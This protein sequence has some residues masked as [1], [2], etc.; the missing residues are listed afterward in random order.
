MSQGGVCKR[1]TLRMHQKEGPM[2]PRMPLALCET[3]HQPKKHVFHSQERVKNLKLNPQSND[4]ACTW[5]WWKGWEVKAS[6]A[7]LF[8]SLHLLSRLHQ[9]P[10]WTR[11]M[12][13]NRKLWKCEAA[14]GSWASSS[15]QEMVPLSYPLCFVLLCHSASESF[16]SQKIDRK[17]H[18][19]GERHSREAE[20]VPDFWFKPLKWLSWTVFAVYEYPFSSVLCRL[21]LLNKAVNK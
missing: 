15:Y 1:S 8:W 11:R 7:S 4:L 6:L 5:V 20:Y 19:G 14:E 12:R 17:R 9:A 3:H 16:T 2:C 10:V 18:L 13:S 21:K